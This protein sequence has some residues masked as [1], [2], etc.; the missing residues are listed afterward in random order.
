MSLKS[1]IFPEL[2]RI[3]KA[4]A[5][6]KRLELID[7]LCQREFGV[8]E[9]AEVMEVSVATTSHHLQI[10][11]NARLVDVRSEGNRR[12]YSLRQGMP[13]LWQTLISV[14][15][16]NLAE[17]QA[18]MA[19]FLD[20]PESFAPVKARELQARIKKGEVLVMDVRPKE[21]FEAGRFPGA[22]SVP[23]EDLDERIRHLPKDREVIA[24]CRG[25]YCLLSH[26]AVNLL[27][28]HGIRARRWPSGVADWLVEGIQLER[29]SAKSEQVKKKYRCRS[30]AGKPKQ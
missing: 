12:C 19:K 13:Q 8:E 20:E 4:L 14:G 18:A 15:N 10:L 29:G 27:R 1:V 16:E 21:E 3:G 2:A 11:K 23:M 9:L 6:S 22:I 7:F 28:Q 30:A 17:I 24:Y 5:S 25:P 26:T